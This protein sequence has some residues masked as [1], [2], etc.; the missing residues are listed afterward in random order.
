MSEGE[1]SVSKSS[2]LG[3]GSCWPSKAGG[4]RASSWPGRNDQKAKRVILQK[5][6]RWTIRYTVSTGCETGAVLPQRVKPCWR[7]PPLRKRARLPVL[8]AG[9]VGVD[10]DAG[11]IPTR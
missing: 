8:F 5:P 10:K 1:I 6:T 7:Q 9:I 3:P 4:R 2:G 11:V